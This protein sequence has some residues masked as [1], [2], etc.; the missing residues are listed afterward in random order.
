MAFK[1]FEGVQ[2]VRGTHHF[3]G[4][5]LRIQLAGCHIIDLRKDKARL[6]VRLRCKF[7]RQR[8]HHI[9]L[10]NL[11]F[12]TRPQ[13][14]DNQRRDRTPQSCTGRVVKGQ[15]LQI[16]N[17]ADGL[18]YRARAHVGQTIGDDG[19]HQDQRQQIGRLHNVLC[20]V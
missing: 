8:S 3:R 2:E 4:H 20:V 9:V 5:K 17:T 7:C 18:G 6:P 15:R 12:K 13:R 16:A 10:D 19:N 14:Q 11:A 1:L